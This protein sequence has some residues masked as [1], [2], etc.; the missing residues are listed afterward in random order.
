MQLLW[1]SPTK[2]HS[3]N[4]FL[5][6]QILLFWNE[7]P[8]LEVNNVLRIFHVS[9]FV[10]HVKVTQWSSLFVQLDKVQGKH[11]YTYTYNFIIIQLH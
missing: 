1:N 8:K 5:H 10:S 11:I 9:A 3:L 4:V 6:V 7:H 2:F